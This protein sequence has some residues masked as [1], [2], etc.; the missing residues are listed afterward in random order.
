MWLVRPGNTD[1]L[2]TVKIEREK[3]EVAMRNLN[4]PVVFG[5]TDMTFFARLNGSPSLAEKRR[6]LDPLLVAVT[7]FLLVLN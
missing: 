6:M 5:L 3:R 7:C 4:L 1:I 2:S